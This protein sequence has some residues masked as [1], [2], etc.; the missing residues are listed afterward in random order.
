MQT[1]MTTRRDGRVAVVVRATERY[2]DRANW[3]APVQYHDECEYGSAVERF[4]VGRTGTLVSCE[5]VGPNR[6]TRGL[7]GVSLWDGPVPGNS[8]RAIRT[9]HGWRGTT[10]DYAVYAHGRRTV[11]S[12]TAHRR[13]MAVTVVLGRDELPDE[14]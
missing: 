10:D 5:Y 12:V 2:I 9:Y 8:N 11:E 1:T 7:R 4:G 14:Q 6:G 13:G 3:R